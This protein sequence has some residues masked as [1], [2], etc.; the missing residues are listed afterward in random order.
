MQS[1]FRR[2]ANTATSPETTATKI[3]WIAANK[4]ELESAHNETHF[5]ANE[6]DGVQSWSSR[7]S[8]QCPL[9][10]SSRFT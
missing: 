8:F 5:I 9:P 3:V 10:A 1:S 2:V 6:G 4:A 7:A